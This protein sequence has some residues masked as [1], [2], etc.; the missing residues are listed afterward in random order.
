MC[1][2]TGDWIDLVPNILWLRLAWDTRT[3]STTTRVRNLVWLPE[4]LPLLSSFLPEHPGEALAGL[5]PDPGIPMANGF[6]I[7]QEGQSGI[8]V[9]SLCARAGPGCIYGCESEVR[10]LVN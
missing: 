10:S 3:E 6:Q 8:Y 9:E 7:H 5:T 4:Y 2:V 1:N